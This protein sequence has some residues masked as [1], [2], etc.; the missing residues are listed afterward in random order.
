MKEAIIKLLKVKSLFSL[1]AIVII[2]L[3]IFYP[4]PD[5][6]QE[7]CK[8]IVIFYFGTQAEKLTKSETAEPTDNPPESEDYE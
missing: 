6:V 2:V 8:T 3:S 1:T 7:I 5:W 4:I